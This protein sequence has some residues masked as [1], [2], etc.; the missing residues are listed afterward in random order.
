M[1]DRASWKSTDDYIVEHL[2]GRDSDLEGALERNAEGG[3]PAIDVSRTQVE[4]LEL[5]VRFG[6]AQRVLEVGTLGGYSTIGLARAVGEAG[7]VTTLELIPH[8]AEVAAA[9]LVAAGLDDRVEVQ[10]GPALELLEA[11]AGEPPAP[12]DFVFIDADKANSPEY[13]GLARRLCRPGAMIVVDNVIRDGTLA[14]AS[15]VD[16]DTV[17]NRRLHAMLKSDKAVQ[18]TTIQT[19]GHKGWDGFTIAIV[20]SLSQKTSAGACS[21]IKA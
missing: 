7:S 21:I 9:N 4:L 5:L 2:L 19:V 13:F 17:G 11:M 1:S 6:G 8:H 18:A 10:V 3:L 12:F 20:Q 14:D 16:P 15:A